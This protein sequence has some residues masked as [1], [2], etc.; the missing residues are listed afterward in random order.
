[1]T[2]QQPTART[3]TVRRRVAFAVLLVLLSMLLLAAVSSSATASTPGL[4]CAD[5]EGGVYY[6]APSNLTVADASNATV[7]GPFVATDAIT[8][9]NVTVR[10]A[11]DAFV[12][13]HGH[14]TDGT[15]L[16]AVNA[17]TTPLTVETE[18]GTLTVEGRVDAL[19]FDDP[20]VGGDAIAYRT[21]ESVTV[22]IADSGVEAGTTVEAVDADGNVL[23]E[24]T[25][26]DDGS[27]SLSL[28]ARTSA[29]HLS[30]QTV[31]AE[32]TTARSTETDTH[33]S[34]EQTPPGSTTAS[35]PPGT[36]TTTSQDTG[37]DASIGS[38]DSPTTAG[39]ASGAETT[40]ETGPGFGITA[41]LLA[42]V[43]VLA[44]LAV[45][46]PRR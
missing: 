9:D 44:L 24:A 26:A 31:Q 11:G 8:L 41:A 5:G 6:T 29:T 14:G 16:S 1:M 23:T 36:G 21:T 19:A 38:S 42:V 35:T 17:T 33:T 46:A 43:G 27:L 45:Q 2:D 10:A 40:G 15:C 39:T 37:T 13:F 12:R 32:T 25:V 4:S 30:L 7:H 18:A 28:P 20:T 34:R 3:G 22:T